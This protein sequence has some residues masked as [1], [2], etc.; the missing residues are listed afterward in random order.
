MWVDPKARRK[1][2]GVVAQAPVLTEAILADAAVVCALGLELAP[3]K[4]LEWLPLAI[5]M[6][7]LIDALRGGAGIS[8]A[9]VDQLRRWA[10]QWAG[11]SPVL[12]KF[13]AEVATTPAG[14][15]AIWRVMEG[16]H[17]TGPLRGDLER[18]WLDSFGYPPN[19][20]LFPIKNR[21]IPHV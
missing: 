5:K 3:L 12:R 2:S 20:Q 18:L 10:Q 15:A 6:E 7:A 14:E 11:L 1:R 17:L 4:G 21:S 19:I 9:D 13:Y 16:G 8:K